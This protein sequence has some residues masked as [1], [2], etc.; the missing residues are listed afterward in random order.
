VILL[1]RIVLCVSEEQAACFP[2]TSVY[3]QETTNRNDAEDHNLNFTIYAVHQIL[4]D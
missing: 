3:N 2:E 1:R 4:D